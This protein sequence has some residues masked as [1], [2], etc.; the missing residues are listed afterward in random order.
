M[1]IVRLGLPT[2]VNEEAGLWG[3]RSPL[4]GYLST[5]R[6]R[7]R[8]AGGAALGALVFASTT[9][10]AQ[11]KVLLRAGTVRGVVQDTSRRN[12][13]SYALVTVV[14]AGRR[15]FASAAGT[16]A[17]TGLEPGP[18]TLRVLQIGYAPLAI[19]IVLVD[20]S[21][22]STGLE[23]L[24]VMLGERVFILPEIAV[25]VPSGLRTY[26]QP[27]S[28]TPSE[29]VVTG[30]AGHLVLNQAVTNAERILVLE[31]EYPFEVTYEHIR[32]AEDALGLPA[33]RWIDTLTIN[34]RNRAEYRAGKVLPRGRRDATYFTVADLARP[35]FQ[36]AHCAWYVS[37]DSVEGRAVHR[38]EF[39]PAPGYSDPD[40]S[41]TLSFDA[42]SFE[43][44]QSEAW[45]VNVPPQRPQ[46]RAARCV[47]RYW[48][49]IPT[50]VRERAL[51]C[52][53]QHGGTR[54]PTSRESYRVIATKF[55]GPRPGEPH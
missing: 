54:F 55:I 5:M 15:V 6:F 28:C 8:I 52:L 27:E 23:R 26:H 29:R 46:L 4:S 22:D 47:A 41:G 43:L 24:E 21:V 30:T 1:A 48:A 38:V 36:Q 44:V 19:P 11:P 18:D 39:E 10:A 20:A 2:D 40:W 17:I 31:Q 34:S 9:A 50:L 37:T 33:A 13:L 25:S 7:A 42:E 3:S 49:E 51:L 14:G 16:F 35:A 45:L 12:G 53:A 32:Q